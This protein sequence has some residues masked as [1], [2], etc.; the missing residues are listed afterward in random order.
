VETNTNESLTTSE[1][2]EKPAVTETI[3]GNVAEEEAPTELTDD[4]NINNNEE[5]EIE[6]DEDG[7]EIIPEDEEEV[8]EDLD[9]IDYEA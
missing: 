6:Y 3:E 4:V 2:I 9:S 5:R 8:P 1:S 7:N